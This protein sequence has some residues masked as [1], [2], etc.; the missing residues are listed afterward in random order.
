MLFATLTS[1]RLSHVQDVRFGYVRN[2]CLRPLLTDQ[3]KAILASPNFGYGRLPAVVKGLAMLL[4][5]NRPPSIGIRRALCEVAGQCQ[6]KGQFQEIP[7]SKGL[8]AMQPSLLSLTATQVLRS[9]AY[10]RP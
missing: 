6:D 8:T 4:L 2:G 9:Q 1:S 10:T 5:H 3:L 7:M